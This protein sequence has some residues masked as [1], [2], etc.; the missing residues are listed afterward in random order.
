MSRRSGQRAL[1]CH[2]ELSE[3][4]HS[5]SSRVPSTGSAW[6]ELVTTRAFL[7]FAALTWPAVAA[8]YA[9]P[10]GIVVRTLSWYTI[11]AYLIFPFVVIAF[12]A[13]ERGRAGSETTPRR[14][15]T[16]FALL[17]LAWMVGWVPGLISLGVWRA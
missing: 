6:R 14:V 7:V 1:A 2:G 4:L 9:R 10:Q 15:V 13:R 12:V 16:M 8:P 3:G 11:A 17:S 5:V